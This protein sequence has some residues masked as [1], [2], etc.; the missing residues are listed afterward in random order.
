MAA[1]AAPFRAQFPVK[2]TGEDGYSIAKFDALVTFS[3]T[4]WRHFEQCRLVRAR[5][6]ETPPNSTK[7]NG[8]KCARKATLSC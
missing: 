4:A 2:N 7:E 8:E 1:S 3:M 6:T 5:P